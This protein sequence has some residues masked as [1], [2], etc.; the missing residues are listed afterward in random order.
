MLNDIIGDTRRR[1]LAT[2]P[3]RQIYLRS[4]GEVSYFSLTTRLQLGVITG[5]SLMALWCLFSIVNM[6]FDINPLKSPSS[7]IRQVEARY[8]RLLADIT[9]KQESTQALLIEQRKSFE[10]M[11]ANLEAKHQTLSQIVSSDILPSAAAQT[12]VRYAD[13]NMVMAPTKRDASERIA[14]RSQIKPV[15]IATGLPI[16]SALI[17]LDDTQN[18]ILLTAE[19]E[20]LDQIETNR[21][22]IE[23]TDMD[24][25]DVL[26]Q[27]TGGTGG[28]FIPLDGFGEGL[29]PGEFHPRVNEVQARF[30]E[31]EALEAAVTSMPLGH[32]VVD[33]TY[34]TSKFGVRSD[35]FT[36][37]PTFHG[38]IDFGGR[39]MA[40]IQA[41]AAGTVIR[42]GRNGALGLM[43]EI[44]HGHGFTTRYGHLKKTFVKRGQKVE[45]GTKIGGMGSTGRSSGTHLHYEVRFNGRGYDPK[46]FLEAGQH[47]Q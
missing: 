40:P 14:R 5:V 7:E 6:I 10:T 2:F 1:I 29:K 27:G 4:S 32:P 21:A 44:D 13:A 12:S 39:P 19:R 23:K 25:S 30:V 8:E 37:R 42:A 11:A 9:A 46:K 35:P 28:P 36:R 34:I 26:E 43:V 15:D 22:L 47:V 45:K 16:D 38:G 3:D 17:S 18:E 31:H 41:T 33:E 24:I 20:L